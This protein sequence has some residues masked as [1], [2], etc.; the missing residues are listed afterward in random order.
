[1]CKYI[2]IYIYIHPYVCIHTHTYI[3][4]YIHTYI[5]LSLSIYIYIYIYICPPEASTT[6]ERDVWARG[7]GRVARP[8]AGARAEAQANISR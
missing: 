6:I 1:M 7:G 4:I 2:Y 5:S 8:S 3:Y